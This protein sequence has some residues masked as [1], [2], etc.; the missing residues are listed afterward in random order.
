M[1]PLHMSQ[2]STNCVVLL[3]CVHNITYY[4]CRWVIVM[5]NMIGSDVTS[6]EASEQKLHI[7]VQTALFGL[8]RNGKRGI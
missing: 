8:G 4:C 6:F 7:E 3:I 2:T 1:Y 5:M